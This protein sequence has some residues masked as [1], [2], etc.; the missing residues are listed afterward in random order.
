MTRADRLLRGGPVQF[1]SAAAMMGH[2]WGPEA[3][4]G[5][6]F[7]WLGPHSSTRPHSWSLWRITVKRRLLSGARCPPHPSGPAWCLHVAS[8]KPDSRAGHQVWELER[9]IDMRPGAQSR[10][11]EKAY[12]WPRWEQLKT[13]ACEKRLTEPRPWQGCLGMARGEVL[14]RV[15]LRAQGTGMYVQ[16]WSCKCQ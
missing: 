16:D 5:D 14:T 8:P 4:T 6:F 12:T 1:L 2:A 11:I 13:E 10:T 15:I 3:E 9:A 7:V